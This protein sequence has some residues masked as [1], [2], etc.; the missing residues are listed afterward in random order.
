M[1]R[2]ATGTSRNVDSIVVLLAGFTSTA[3]RVAAGTNSRRISTFRLQ[4]VNEKID[5]GRIA[6]R[7]GGVSD[8]TKSD[9]VFT[10]AEHD[11]DR[12]G[13][14]LGRQRRR[15]ASA[16][17]DDGDLPA[18]QVSCQLRKSLVATLRRAVY[19]RHVLALDEAHVLQ[20][21]A[22]CAQT[23]RVRFY[24]CAEEQSDHRHRRLLRSRRERPCRCSAAEQHNEVAPSHSITSSARARTGVG[25]SRPRLLAVL[26]LITSSYLVGA[27]TGR[28]TGFSPLR[29]RS[30]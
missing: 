5:P 3:T 30:T 13:G 21:L 6:T 25:I 23:M 12:R 29:M 27:C 19:D 17:G 24:C 22:K 7:P 11:R 9:R 15:S 26:R 1:A 2:A 8:E 28:S 10:H 4:L 18:N 20:P 16:R 14:G